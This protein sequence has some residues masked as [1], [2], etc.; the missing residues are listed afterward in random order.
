MMN[1]KHGWKLFEQDPKGN[2][3]PLFLDKDTIY[4]MNKWINAEIHYGWDV[5]WEWETPNQENIFELIAI[6]HTSCKLAT[7][8]FNSFDNS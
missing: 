7:C 8:I 4:P 2:L 6:L 3:Y 5:P 1:T